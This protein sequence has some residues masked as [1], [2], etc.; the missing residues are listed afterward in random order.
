VRTA[1]PSVVPRASNGRAD[2]EGASG[3]H[4][5]AD[6]RAWPA[7][8]VAAAAAT[9]AAAGASDGRGS[10]GGVRAARFARGRRRVGSR[11]WRSPGRC[12]RRRVVNDCDTVTA[13]RHTKTALQSQC[14]SDRSGPRRVGRR[15]QRR[16]APRQP[17]RPGGRAAWTAG[18][19]GIQH[20]RR[21]RQTPGS[22]GKRMN[23]WFVGV[24]CTLVGLAPQ[25]QYPMDA[26]CRS[27]ASCT[28]TTGHGIARP[29]AQSM[30]SVSYRQHRRRPSQ[31]HA[32]SRFDRACRSAL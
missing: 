29:T 28:Q 19:G 11:G 10:G 16:C 22:A 32:P 25:V 21:A 17:G 18:T 27:N 9:A 30:Q 2:D 7:D 13:R 31:R 23:G 3:A 26:R 6:S 4:H 5:D 14:G 1:R 24:Y 12:A 15:P 20:I 8:R